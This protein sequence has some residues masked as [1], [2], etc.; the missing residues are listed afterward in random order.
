MAAK[1][2]LVLTLVSATG[3]P[4][5]AP[6]MLE[7]PSME[8]CQAAA[9]A[10][11]EATA[12]AHSEKAMPAMAKGGKF[13]AVQVDGGMWVIRYDRQLRTDASQSE[14]VIARTVRAV[15]RPVG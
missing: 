15:C 8:A 12:M 6:S 13:A 9:R 4:Q 5:F 2:L 10:A 3:D 11:V 1:A 14:S 7:Q